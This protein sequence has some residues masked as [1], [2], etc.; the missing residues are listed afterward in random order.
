M[1]SSE[2]SRSVI[3]NRQGRPSENGSVLYDLDEEQADRQFA[4]AIPLRASM[5]RS[6]DCTHTYTRTRTSTHTLIEQRFP[7]YNLV[8]QGQPS[9]SAVSDE[10]VAQLQPDDGNFSQPMEIDRTSGEI[11]S[12]IVSKNQAMDDPELESEQP[13]SPVKSQTLKRDSI[14]MAKSPEHYRSE[15]PLHHKKRKKNTQLEHHESGQGKQSHHRRGAHEH[16]QTQLKNSRHDNEQQYT[17][18]PEHGLRQDST[19]SHDN[20]G[21][22]DAS[23]EGSEPERTQDRGHYHSH[24]RPQAQSKTNPTLCDAN[25]NESNS[26]AELHDRPQIDRN[27]KNKSKSSPKVLPYAGGDMV[28]LDNAHDEKPEGPEMTPQQP[29][30]SDYPS[31]S[32]N[33]ESRSPSDQSPSPSSPSS[34]QPHFKRAAED[35]SHDAPASKGQR[36]KRELA[37]KIPKVYPPR[38]PRVRPAAVETLDMT[39]R[40]D[41]ALSTLA[42]AA[43]AIKD[44]QGPLSTLS[45]LPLSP[46]TQASQ[47]PEASKT[48]K[49]PQPS[50]PPSGPSSTPPD[51]STTAAT[52]ASPPRP[53][54][55]PSHKGSA[56][57]DSGGYQ[58]DLCPGERFGRVHDLKRHQ[59][60]KHNEMTWPCDFCYRPFVRRDALLRHYSVKAARRDGVHPTEQEENR[61]QEAKARA[62]LLS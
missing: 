13:G 21:G 15:L 9:A 57:H 18:G 59:I 39:I 23:D 47:T 11:P 32:P 6:L 22:A 49:P 25:P 4:G 14:V 1:G 44:H 52:T 2:E 20:D 3:G 10:S 19:E 33:V 45:V 35:S 34:P 31:P 26:D 30:M 56:P 48:P 41:S 55:R 16:S 24:R 43:V 40:T 7:I 51:I 36:S 38:K 62:K 42:S 46:S 53:T 17:Q 61:L 60:S 54:G 8:L 28:M 27:V 37:K 5:T 29:A 50:S 58:C 12:K